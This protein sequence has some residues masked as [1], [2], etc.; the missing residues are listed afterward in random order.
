MKKNISNHSVKEIAIKILRCCIFGASMGLALQTLFWLSASWLRADGQ[1]YF[2]S[3]HLV[4]MYGTELGAVTAQCICSA[5]LGMLWA[6]A[7]LIFRETDWSIMKQ[8][9]I[10]FSVCVIP[11]L[12]FACGMHWMPRSFDGL[13]QYLRL[14]LVLYGVNWICQF[15]T[16]RKRVKV[17]NERLIQLK[18]EAGADAD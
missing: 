1:L 9:F 10:H 14:F 16:I 2:V 3:G 17:F 11:S 5:I 6:S 13:K 4:M 7:T 15:L 8:T 12:L 18:N